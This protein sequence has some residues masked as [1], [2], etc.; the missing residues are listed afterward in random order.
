M[1]YKII[2]KYYEDELWTKEQVKTAVEKNKITTIE[3]K[4]IVGE[5]YIV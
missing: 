2:K 4:N 1:W 3:Y 5:D